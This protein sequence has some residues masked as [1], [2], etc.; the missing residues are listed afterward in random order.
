MA[1]RLPPVP[2]RVVADDD[3]RDLLDASLALAQTQL[4]GQL[5]DETSLD[6]RSMGTLGFNG[7][8]LAADIAAKSLLGTFWWT[9]LVV[10]GLATA[11]CLGP[12]ASTH[13]AADS[14][15]GA[16]CRPDGRAERRRRVSPA[17]LAA[18]RQLVAAAHR[19]VSER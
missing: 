13:R 11:C 1:P 5:A 15:T 2:V 7:A 3:G 8:L 17:R 6:A 19:S 4:V 10:I 12:A 14:V 16:P 18:S 9:P